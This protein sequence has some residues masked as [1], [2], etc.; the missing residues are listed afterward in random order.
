[1]SFLKLVRYVFITLL[2][3]TIAQNTFAQNIS[4][5]I[6]P[7]GFTIQVWDA[8]SVNAYL[9]KWDPN[10]ILGVTDPF[11]TRFPVTEVQPTQPMYFV[12]VYT[13]PNSGPLGSFI[14]RASVVR[15]L[16]RQQIRDIL[17]LPV[18]PVKIDYVK[19]PGGRKYGLWTGIAG[20]IMSPGHEWGNG[21]GLQTKI[22]GQETNPNPPPDLPRWADYS[23]L[24]PES[25]MNVQVIGN[26]AL[27]YSEVVKSGNAGKVAAYLDQHLPQPYSD[28]EMV[29][30]TLDYINADGPPELALALNQ[31]SPTVFD[32][33]STTLFRNDLLFER[34]LLEHPLGDP[35]PYN[36]NCFS[37]WLNLAG[38]EGNQ[39]QAT[40]RIGYYYQTAALMSGADCR[41][42]PNFKVGAGAGYMRDH[43]G[44]NK[45]A[46][47]AEINNGK[48]GVYASYGASDY[49]VNSALTAGYS[50]STATRHMNFSGVGIAVLSQLVVDT[51]S[52]NRTATSNQYGGNVGFYINGGKNFQFNEWNILPTAQISYFY[53]EQDT[54][55]ESGAGDL[56]L[57]VQ[58]F[59]AQTIR[60]QLALLLGKMFCTPQTGIIK[61]NVQLGWAHNFPLDNR[62]I[63]ASL[64]SLG[65]AFSVNGDHQETN[66]L[67]AS[68]NIG[69]QVKKRFWIDAQ[70]NAFFSHGF[71]SQ[72]LALIVKYY[73]DI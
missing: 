44:W 65:G 41:I 2:L 70:Y 1:M 23:R 55:N 24:P 66:E 47:N 27:S 16:T 60:T 13:E 72:A 40:D 15:G 4:P 62:V 43:L 17:A 52:V 18:L 59:D 29:Y 8:A 31:I 12:R 28:M 42:G 26:K 3:I 14:V 9:A 56:N 10:I 19:V 25:Y 73:I 54:F 71:N 69:T 11:D 33:Y 49:F 45:S 5:I 48:I 37:S 32:T 7:L 38:E 57:R 67:I 35:G 34:S 30:A 51:L 36:R 64:P 63:T 61:T 22:I 68:A 20:P 58:D 6:Q 39:S 21:G 53:S 50:W 46:G